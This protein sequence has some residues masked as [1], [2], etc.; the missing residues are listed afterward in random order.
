MKS[1]KV[2]TITNAYTWYNKGDSGILLATI[3]I[4]KKVYD[5]VEFNILSFT[6]NVDKKHYCEDKSV[7]NVYSNVLNPYPYRKGKVGKIIAI[8]KLFFKMI[9]MQFGLTFFR[10]MTIKK[11]EN[12]SALQKSDMIVVCGGGFLGGKKLDSLM[13]VYQIYVD[14]IFHKPVYVMGTSIEPTKSKFV[15]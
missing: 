5:N 7:K 13:H 3:D 9:S 6:P 15:K 12:L 11:H 1:K 4:L 14:T 8:V 10:N 2:I